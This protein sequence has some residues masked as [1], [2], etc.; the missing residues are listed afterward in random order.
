MTAQT[1]PTPFGVRPTGLALEQLFRDGAWCEARILPCEDLVLA[2]QTRVLHYAQSIFEGFKAHR[3][4]GGG[5]ALFRPQAHL[6]RFNR[7]AQRMCLPGMD[8]AALLE[9][10]VELVGRVREEV[11]AAPESLYVRPFLFGDDGDLIAGPSGGA[12]LLVLCA[13]VPVY[14]E[15]EG[16]VLLRTETEL[17]RAHPGGTGSIKAAGNYAGAMLA[18]RRARE[19]GYDEV[20]WLDPVD[21]AH[22]EETGSM[23]LFLVRNG[24]LHTAPAG[25]TVLPG[26]TRES[27]L[28]LAADQGLE[29]CVERIPLER[30]WW[31]GVSEVFSSGTAVGCSPVARIDHRGELFWQ[32]QEAATVQPALE[33]ALFDI[34]EG[35]AAD[36]HGWRVDC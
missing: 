26:I 28:T 13:P 33:R 9:Q 10:I 27:L 21:R 16:G 1:A 34:K 19:E 20:V 24:V 15:R 29:T 25:E 4:E 12:R 5:V 14:F 22:V 32:R 7:S 31:S 30:D 18:Q 6:A 8:E 35:R 17:V 2:P 3:Q 11:P 23:N 36:P